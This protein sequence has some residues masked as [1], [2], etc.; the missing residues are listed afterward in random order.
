MII[1]K[2]MELSTPVSKVRFVLNHLGLDYQFD[3]VNLMAGEGQKPEILKLNPSGKVPILQDGE[4]AIWESNAII[5]YLARRQD[6]SLYPTDIKKQAI[7]DQWMDFGSLHIS[8]NMGKIMYSK[9]FAP[10]R[11]EDIDE[12]ALAEG[13]KFIARFLPIVDA[14]L[15]KNKYL[16]GSELT[17]ADFTMLAALDPAEV[18]E[19]NISA[20][21]NLNKWRSDLHKQSFYTKCYANYQDALA[22]L[23]K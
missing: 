11:G 15:G 7:V 14:Q 8:I 2:G 10:L 5:K 13:K 9:I 18:C 16:T 17:L 21:P 23:K 3:R 12:R 20:Y 4:F 19:V 1:L 6:S 22:A